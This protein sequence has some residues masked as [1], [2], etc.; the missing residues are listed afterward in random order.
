MQF[1]HTKCSGALQAGRI[2]LLAGLLGTAAC[3]QAQVAKPAAGAAASTQA[4]SIDKVDFKRGEDGSGKLILGFSGDGAMP[5]LR[6][7]GDTVIIDLGSARLPASLQKIMNVSDFATP[8][9][10]VDAAGNRLVL[11]T[12]APFA[13]MAYQHGREYIVEI[14]PKASA[15]AVGGMM[16]S[17][18]ATAAVS[19][20]AKSDASTYSGRPVNFNFQDVPVRTVLQLIAETAGLN[21]VASDT[22]QGNI[23]LRL[24]NVPWDKALDVILKTKGLDKRRDGNVIWVAPQ[25]EI[26]KGEQEKEDARIALENRQDLTTEYFRINYHNANE[27]Y[28]AITE[29][30]GIGNSSNG[31]SGGGGN[32]Q[33]QNDNGFLS[34]RGR[35]VADGRTNTLM[36]S[37]IPKKLAAMRA[38]INEIDRPVDQVVI[39]SRIV[40]A[41]ETFARDLGA[42]FGIGM[43]GTFN[44]NGYKYG[45]GGT[46][47]GSQANIGGVT[48]NSGSGLNF[49]LPAASDA[50][51]A[52][53]GYSILGANFSLDLE[54]SA[55]QAEGRGEILANPRI[56]TTNQRE[57]VIQQGSQIGYVTVTSS[58]GGAVLPQVQFK[59]VLLELRVTPTITND[60][61]VFL[62]VK[63]TK[64]DLDSWLQ[65]PIGNVPIIAKR[66][67]DTAVLMDNGQTVVIGGVYEFKNTDTLHKVPF[68]GDLPVIGNLF[69]QKSK[70]NSK[71]ELLV[72]L[73][74]RI[75][76][77]KQT[78]H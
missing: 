39:E 65:T 22:V 77:V 64:D 9:D 19:A 27:I 45:V 46:N 44:H 10:R 66:A 68:L 15:N 53:I 38:L 6:N 1:N 11:S 71:A 7:Q 30:K 70:S 28:K 58:S 18:V 41:T 59:D 40:I 12:R 56:F 63:V 25:A 37:D 14:S 52:S 17:M 23:T 60:D 21:V 50:T 24:Q 49:N 20:R 32:N 67:V 35:I 5:D 4:L 33:S 62:I 34:P 74:P 72:F 31:G 13:S 16:S 69:R 75:I 42:K 36:V 3:A 51:A 26:A 2:A 55:M 47:A 54:L 73:T 48:S 8:V 78:L 57:S 76:R 43:G 29:A 61:R